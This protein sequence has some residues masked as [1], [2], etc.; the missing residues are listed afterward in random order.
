MSRNKGRVSPTEEDVLEQEVPSG[1]PEYP[2]RPPTTDDSGGFN[3][4]NPTYFVNLPSKGR[5]YPPGHP[6]H[7][8]EA[9][10]IKYMTAK[11]EDFLTSQPLIR[12]GIAIDRVLES[13]IIDKSIHID[14]LLLGDRNAL[15]IGTRITGYGEEYKVEVTCPKCGK[16]S[17]YEFDLEKI[18]T[19]DY[20]EQIKELGCEFTPRNTVSVDLP[21]SKVNV[22]I[23]LLNGHDEK[24]L[25]EQANKKSKK[26]MP[27]SN[28]TDQLRAFIVSVNGI[29]SPFAVANFVSQMPAR[30]SKFLRDLYVSIAPNV[31]L[32]QEFECQ[33]CGHEADMEVPLGVGFFWPE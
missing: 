6:V 9:I 14:D 19:N 30:D 16:E 29:D 21:L 31:D 15:M 8:K 3:W 24:N 28:L 5:F 4:T 13:V 11:E 20:E 1:Y 18:G 26:N 25:T 22:E 17:D 23:R 10:E 7:N 33:K 2:N 27:T 32:V 12:K